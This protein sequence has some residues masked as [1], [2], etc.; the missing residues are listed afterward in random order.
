M[1]TEI[2]GE[3]GTDRDGEFVRTE[4]EDERVAVVTSSEKEGLT[5]DLLSVEKLADSGKVAENDEV[6]ETDEEA[7]SDADSISD[8]EAEKDS[9]SVVRRSQKSP[10]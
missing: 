4:Q 9:E 8:I 3:S 6:E 2:D 1:K 7:E 5:A 10:V